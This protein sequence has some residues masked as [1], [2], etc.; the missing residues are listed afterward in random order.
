MRI[1]TIMATAVARL[2]LTHGGGRVR[3][4]EVRVTTVEAVPAEPQDAGAD[5]DE[6]Q[7]VRHRLL[8][9]PLEARADDRGGHEAGD[10]GG[11]VDDV[12]AGEVER[13]LARPVAAAPEEEGVDRV[14]E[15]DPQR[16]EDHPRLEADPAEHRADEQDRGDR[17]EHELEVLDRRAR[18]PEA[19][20]EDLTGLRHR[21][22]GHRGVNKRDARLAFQGVGAKDSPRVTEHVDAAEMDQRRAEAH[23]VGPQ[24][25]GDEDQAEGHENHE[26]G[27]HGPLLLHQAAVQHG[28]GR[29]GHKPDQRRRCHLPGV[30]SRTQPGRVWNHCVCSSRGCL[31]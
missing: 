24:H 22:P 4:R 18:Q 9:V 2:V 10:A 21:V 25:P 23:L 30:I 16:N 8:P 3:A 11:E 12:T 19:G 13:A 27:V 1:Q 15:G 14:G 5:R 31:I 17:G 28:Q 29:D 20:V 26:R 6:H 7:V